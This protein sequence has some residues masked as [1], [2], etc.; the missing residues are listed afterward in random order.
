MR[1][2]CVHV[3]KVGSNTVAW[4]VVFF[5]WHRWPTIIGVLILAMATPVSNYAVRAI[6]RLRGAMLKAA[7]SRIKL[8]G[9]FLAGVSGGR[10]G[11]QAGG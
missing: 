9:Q 8:L 7:D 6:Q 3:C 5:C 10:G 2:V 11:P 1:D 4:W